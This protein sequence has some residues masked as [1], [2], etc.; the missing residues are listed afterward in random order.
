M[1]KL[2]VNTVDRCSP[3][4]S[5]IHHLTTIVFGDEQQ[6]VNVDFKHPFGIGPSPDLMCSAL[7]ALSSVIYKFDWK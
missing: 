3:D 4:G 1:L 2:T 5:N 6:G 7:A